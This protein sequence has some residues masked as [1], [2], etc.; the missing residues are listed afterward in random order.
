MH[1]GLDPDRSNA[2]ERLQE[3]ADLLASG[4]RRLGDRH[5]QSRNNSN[6]SHLTDNSLDFRRRQSVDAGVAGDLENPHAR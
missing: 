6:F 5:R 2:D 1:N 4:L 3:I